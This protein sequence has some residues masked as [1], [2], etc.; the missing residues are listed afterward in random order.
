MY[1]VDFGISGV[2][3]I[4]GLFAVSINIA[5]VGVYKMS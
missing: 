1:L 5:W 2:F 4:F 3:E